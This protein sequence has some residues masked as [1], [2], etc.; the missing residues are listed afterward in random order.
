MKN[1]Y[2]LAKQITHCNYLKQA[3]PL[4]GKYN[5]N[6]WEKYIIK[7]N[8]YT[9]NKF[10]INKKIEISIITWP[11]GFESDY[12]NHAIGG[13]LFK[14]MRGSIEENNYNMWTRNNINTLHEGDI[15][16]I[17]D[18]FGIHKIKNVN[19]DYSISLHVYSPPNHNTIWFI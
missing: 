6:D 9:K 3:I 4:L 16:Y 7:G 12:H 19:N 18:T 11:P 8:N 5:G 1:L 10:F 17:D 2:S 15:R 14:C 13:C